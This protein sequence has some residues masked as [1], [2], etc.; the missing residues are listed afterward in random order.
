MDELLEQIWT[1]TIAE[2]RRE[3]ESLGKELGEAVE[4][5]G[6]Y[7]AERSKHLSLAV[8]EPGFAETLRVEVQNVALY[9]G[10]RAVEE[11]D[12]VDERIDKFL[13]FALNAA[14]KMISTVV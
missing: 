7:A 13:K 1:E 3:A 5:A 12:A 6:A 4:E 2:L 11:A 14:A 9:A 8:G 10:L